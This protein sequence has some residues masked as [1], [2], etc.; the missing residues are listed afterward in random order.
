MELQ[1]WDAPIFQYSDDILIIR[2][3]G[4]D[5]VILS[6][7]CTRTSPIDLISDAFHNRDSNRLLQR[8]HNKM[9]TMMMKTMILKMMRM[10]V[11]SIMTEKVSQHGY[12]SRCPSGSNAT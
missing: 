4:G 1:Y 3:H 5:I 9:T 10:K 6:T 12:D 11:F 8:F 2:S 7:K